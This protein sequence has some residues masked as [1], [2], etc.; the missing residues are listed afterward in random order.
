ME[1]TSALLHQRQRL[2]KS[3]MEAID[4]ATMAALVGAVVLFIN[5][6][7]SA[8]DQWSAKKNG[9]TVYDNVKRMQDQ[10]DRIEDEVKDL[11]DKMQRTHRDL[12]EFRENFNTYT[13][14]RKGLDDARKE[15]SNG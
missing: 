6:A 5:K 10:A 11:R 8:L 3:Q 2:S 15:G 4:H 13:A 12:C 9:G 14:Y 1:Q 7:S